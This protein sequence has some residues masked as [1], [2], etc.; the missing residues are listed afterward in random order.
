MRAEISPVRTS[1]DQ[2]YQRPGFYF[3]LHPI[4]GAV[5]CNSSTSLFEILVLR[6]A[7]TPRVCRLFDFGTSK[8]VTILV[9]PPCSNII[10]VTL[11]CLRC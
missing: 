7:E 8:L 4:A 6:L 11:H 9:A 3:L 5:L 1:T 10:V 2:I